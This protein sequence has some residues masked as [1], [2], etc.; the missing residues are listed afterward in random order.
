MV[1]VKMAGRWLQKCKVVKILLIP[2]GINRV[3]KNR[4]LIFVSPLS[5]FKSFGLTTKVIEHD[6]IILYT[7]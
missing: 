3:N 6:H 2:S 4:G 1:T 5:L 7:Q